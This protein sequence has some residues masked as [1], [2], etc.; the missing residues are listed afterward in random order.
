MDLGRARRI[1]RPPGI[2]D[3]VSLDDQ[4][5]LLSLSSLTSP[6][7]HL[8]QVV[9]PPAVSPSTVGPRRTQRK[10]SRYYPRAIASHQ[11]VSC[12]APPAAHHPLPRPPQDCPLQSPQC[13]QTT[14]IALTTRIFPRR[15]APTVG[16]GSAPMTTRG[17]SGASPCSSLL[18]RSSKTLKRILIGLSAGA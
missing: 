6:P 7:S 16:N 14:S 4:H 2:P 9:D 17:R 18:W 11:S 10:A 15:H 5:R 13:N 8:A 1:V 12:L 3:E